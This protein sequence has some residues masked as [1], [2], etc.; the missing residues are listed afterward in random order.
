MY[1]F[2]KCSNSRTEIAFVNKYFQR[3]RPDLLQYIVRKT[4]T[5]SQTAKRR[6]VPQFAAHDSEFPK[7]QPKRPNHATSSNEANAIT[8]RIPDHNEDAPTLGQTDRS[9]RSQK[10]QPFEIDFA[11]LFGCID[12]L[13]RTLSTL[14]QRT[15]ARPGEDINDQVTFLEHIQPLLGELQAHVA[16]AG[17]CAPDGVREGLGSRQARILKQ[18]MND[19]SDVIQDQRSSSSS[20]SVGGL[21]RLPSDLGPALAVS[22]GETGMGLDGVGIG[23]QQ[24]YDRVRDEVEGETGGVAALLSMGQSCLDQE[25]F[26]SDVNGTTSRNGDSGPPLGGM[27]SQ[28]MQLEK[29]LR[30]ERGPSDE[31][32]IVVARTNSASSGTSIESLEANPSF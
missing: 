12:A 6:Q 17:Q 18:A 20:S 16:S 23:R 3:G 19:K 32:G 14:R 24:S 11:I 21:R 31:I 15:E 28:E 10:S 30:M 9:L 26:K 27:P 5:S 7:P 29:D 8:S 13:G 22:E 4:S 2:H 1:D 25:A